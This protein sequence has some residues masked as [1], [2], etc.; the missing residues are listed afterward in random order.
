MDAKQIRQLEWINFTDWGSKVPKTYVGRYGDMLISKQDLESF[1]ENI[2]R[3]VARQLNIEYSVA[4]QILIEENT[5]FFDLMKKIYQEYSGLKESGDNIKS[6]QKL[7]MIPDVSSVP[8][9]ECNVEKI[10]KDFETLKEVEKVE[11]LE[12]LK[13]ISVHIKYIGD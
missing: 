4:Q 1:V 12:R 9:K 6:L 7:L 2:F 13:L 3:N 10:L 8:K 11:V 5:A